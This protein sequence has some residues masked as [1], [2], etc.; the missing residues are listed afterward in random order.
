MRSRLSE[1]DRMNLGELEVSL[2]QAQDNL[3]RPV[4]APAKPR[5]KAAQSF[6]LLKPGQYLRNIQPMYILGQEL[7]AELLWH[8]ESVNSL[9]AEVTTHESQ[10]PVSLTISKPDWNTNWQRARKPKESKHG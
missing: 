4:P 6:R 2:K 8:V 10:R 1:S 9:G 3:W 5:A 7:P